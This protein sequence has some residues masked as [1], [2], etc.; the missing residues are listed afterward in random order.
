MVD[1]E[2]LAV[3]L[4][5]LYAFASRGSAD[6]GNG[7]GGNGD[8]GNGGNGDNGNGGGGGTNQDPTASFTVQKSG[9]S[10]SCN[11]SESY[12]PD[13]EI[14]GMNWEAIDSDYN[15]YATGEGE[16]FSHTFENPG[17]YEIRL[18]VT[19]DQQATD[20]AKK[21]VTVGNDGGGGS[22]G[23]D[24]QSPTANA[25]AYY[26]ESGEFIGLD[27]SGSSDPDG[28]IVAYT[29]AVTGP[30]G[31]TE[32]TTGQQV[33]VEP[34]GDGEYSVVLQVEDDDGAIDT[35]E[36]NVTVATDGGGGDPTPDPDPVWEQT[37][38]TTQ[39]LYDRN[40]RAPEEMVAQYVERAFG[41]LG[42]KVDVQTGFSPLPDPYD[43]PRCQENTRTSFNFMND[44]KNNGELPFVAKDSNLLL[45]DTVG[46]GCAGV[47]GSTAVAGAKPIDR[48]R[49]MV[50]SSAEKY[51]RGVHAPLHEI[52]HNMGFSHSPHPGA[53]WNDDS[54]IPG[55]WHR[56]PTVAENG[57]ENICGEWI[58]SRRHDATVRHLYYNDCVADHMSI[59]ESQ[60]V[61]ADRNVLDC[62]H[63]GCSPE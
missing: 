37:I 6:D 48:V 7:D 60:A 50:E 29:W 23:E 8:N 34:W 11:G 1:K 13:G 10:I 55:K 56:T 25:Q 49:S 28:E 45:V 26:S 46:G 39:A 20:T 2:T 63:C 31:T 38:Y 18:Y 9:L 5:G 54:E 19:D 30:D 12:D 59:A 52:G 15:I 16:V 51:H 57:A 47:G 43:D 35:A 27:G 53:A 24:N 14:I 61:T 33:A 42:V 3:G 36:T 4:I 41:R 40:G 32:N 62:R 44:R 22:P 17:T 58:P 21:T